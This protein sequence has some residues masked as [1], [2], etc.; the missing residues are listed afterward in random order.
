M[1]QTLAT[2][3][4]NLVTLFY[5]FILL[6]FYGSLQ[7]TAT[8]QMHTPEHTYAVHVGFRISLVRCF[9]GKITTN[10]DTVTG[11]ICK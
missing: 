8:V 1:V 9:V 11:K 2:K 4:N 10:C 7:V 3:E 5:L 6:S